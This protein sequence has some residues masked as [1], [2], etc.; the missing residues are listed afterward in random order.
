MSR[1]RSLVLIVAGAVLGAIVTALLFSLCQGP[2]STAPDG[3][4]E[5]VELDSGDGDLD[6]GDGYGGEEPATPPDMTGDCVLSGS[7]IGPDGNPARG[8][9]VRIRLLGQPW[10]VAETDLEQV[11]G[12]DGVFSFEGL[13]QNLE[14]QI[15]AWSPDNA[16]SD[17]EDAVCHSKTHLI[18]EPGGSIDFEI[19]DEDG[20]P[21]AGASLILAGSSLWPARTAA[22]DKDGKLTVT[23]LSEGFFVYR[24]SLDGQVA[25]GDDPIE[26][27]P[28]KRS[29]V[30][31]RLQKAPASRVRVTDAATSAP[32]P[33]ARILVGPASASMLHQVYLTDPDGVA[34]IPG[35]LDI[36]NTISVFADGYISSDPMAVGPGEDLE[37]QIFRGAVVRGTVQT[38]RGAPVAGASMIVRQA[39]GGVA[40][41]VPGGP[42]RRFFDRVMRAALA[43]WPSMHPY[44][45]DQFI[46]GPANIPLPPD[47]RPPSMT[48]WGPTDAEG[49]FTVD[50]L[51]A[52]EVSI[53]AEHEE[54]VI[55]DKASVIL[56]PGGKVDGVVVTMR[57][58]ARLSVH[59]LD[60]GGYPVRGAQVS[61]FDE[62]ATQISVAETGTDGFARM[63][64][65]PGSF[66][67]EATADGMVP[68]AARV[69]AAVDGDTKVEIKLPPATEVLRG[70]VVDARGYGVPDVSI[71][72]RSITRG[73][74]QVIIGNTEEDGT[75]TLEGVGRG[76][77]HV[78][79]EQDGKIRAQVPDAGW[80]KEITLV[81]GAEARGEIPIIEPSFAMPEML[82]EPQPL[83][84]EYQ[85]TDDDSPSGVIAISHGSGAGDPVNTD[86]GQAD[87]LI[88]TG[89]P[90]GKGGL[91]I[92]LGGGAG[93]V[94]VKSV[95]PGS[96]VAGAGLAP[97][98]RIL[99]VDGTAVKSPA[100]AR[101]AIEG[102]IGTVVIL[103]VARGADRVS[104]VVQRVRI[105]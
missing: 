34:P 33:G 88:V 64:G 37:I 61:V 51:A 78:T 6:P 50:G 103:N 63:A 73:L 74:A 76:S 23:G 75:F 3:S 29:R 44:R 89:P 46:A 81:L 39:L 47:A 15:W 12:E 10:S 66:R 60:E 4:G 57:T 53:G 17:Y 56:E 82:P 21:A 11:T 86:Y 22:A 68:A 25:M 24:V 30:A 87:Q 16:V 42:Q 55:Q 72:A 65:L 28:G 105:R 59:V 101:R 92:T 49:H 98:D 14:Y 40:P 5:D 58:G 7:V 79:A 19:T 1:R 54:F 69:T 48:G 100:H 32:I 97:G 96:L 99:E 2:T 95:S 41:D 18:L 8:A 9:T 102:R 83:P 43:G 80:Q 67:V 31:V 91:P 36:D 45:G 35:L 62:S 38:A 70:R 20:D 93:N 27:V 13:S 90:T 71:T 94:V 52:G 26:V 84:D 85:D 77:Y 104:M